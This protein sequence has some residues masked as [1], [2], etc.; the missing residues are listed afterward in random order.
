VVVPPIIIL[1]GEFTVGPNPVSRPAGS[2]GFFRQGRGISGARLAV[3]D[4]SGNLVRKIS[5]KD[6]N[7]GN[8][9]R[10]QVGSWDLRDRKGRIVAEGAYLL[11]GT[12]TARDGG[13]EKVSLVLG[14]R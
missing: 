5:V 6:N 7:I 14:V 10:R 4:A 3:Y 12:I 9:A 13:K 2:V 8:T 1:A 11:R